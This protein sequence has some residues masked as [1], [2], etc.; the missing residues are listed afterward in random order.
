MPSAPQALYTYSTPSPSGPQV[1]YAYSTPNPSVPQVV[2]GWT[3]PTVGIPLV[4]YGWSEP[5]VTVPLV[6]YGWS[7]LMVSAP[8]VVESGWSS[9]MVSAPLVVDER[10]EVVRV[11]PPGIYRYGP[12]MISDLADIDG[13]LL[14]DIDGSLLADL[15][16]GQIDLYGELLWGYTPPT[17][18][19]I[20]RY[21]LLTTGV[22]ADVDG[23][24]LLD[25]NGTYLL[26]TQELPHVVVAPTGVYGYSPVESSSP[27]EVYAVEVSSPEVDTV[28]YAWVEPAVEVPI[29]IYNNNDEVVPDAP[30]G[31]YEGP[32]GEV[33]EAPALHRYGV[34]VGMLGDADGGL[35]ADV[36][37]GYVIDR[38]EEEPAMSEPASIIADEYYG[39]LPDAPPEV[40][41]V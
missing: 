36:G 1:I 4:L 16:G 35:L 24:A 18:P 34:V 13:S 28:V 39:Y 23:G 17:P 31:V 30:L 41:E 22:L 26:D 27:V 3:A 33:M 38:A 32:G 40:G 14:A 11:A 37:G 20:H 19:G 8:Q 10:E 29:A 6:V 15:D 25:V 21:G 2:Y 12:V 5:L 7:R 9:P